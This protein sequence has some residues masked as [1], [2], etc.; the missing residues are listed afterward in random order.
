MGRQVGVNAVSVNNDVSVTGSGTPKRF[1]I[2]YEK[3]GRILGMGISK[4][5]T[6]N[7]HF[8]S[9]N[10]TKHDGAVVYNSTIEIDSHSDT[11]FLARNFKLFHQQKNMLSYFINQLVSNY[12]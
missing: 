3:S 12:R 11:L 10:S 5:S 1:S 2:Q 7:H 4:I 8:S 6:R 9:N